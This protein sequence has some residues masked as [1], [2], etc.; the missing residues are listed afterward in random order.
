MSE[1]FAVPDPPGAVRWRLEARKSRR[2]FY[3]PT[4]LYTAY[5]VAV[6]VLAFRRPSRWAA[7]AFFAGGVI[8]WTLLEYFVHRYVLHG[9][10]P[11]GPS[12]YRRLTHKHFDHLHLEHHARPWDG[13]HI[14]GTIG[15][16]IHFSAL[17]VALAAFTPLHTGPAFVAGL[18]QAYVV[19]EWVHH[20]VHFYSF[21][22][23]YFR[24]IKRH[25]LFHHS[26]KGSEVGFGLTSG[27]W[28]VVWGTRIP[29]P[30]WSALHA[31]K[32]RPRPAAEEPEGWWQRAR[33]ALCRD[34]AA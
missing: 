11:D 14:S 20:S 13:K 1:T 19:E 2:R 6:L 26:P 31:S 28:D 4:V 12:L 17:F 22:N 3:P 8:A 15:D 5:S 34:E 25:H 10:F 21:K 16:T 9:R 30:D 18:L 24:Y 29:E 23:R 33:R 7:L 32:G 27:L